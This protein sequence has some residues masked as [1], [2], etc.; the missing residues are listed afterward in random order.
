MYRDVNALIKKGILR[1]PYYVNFVLGMMYQGAIDATPE[2]LF[3]M[4]SF[5]PENAY[6]NV[7]ATSREQLP[8]T[9]M[10]ILMGGGCRVGLEDNIYYAKGVLAKSNAQLVARSVRIAREL[11]IEPLSAKDAREILHI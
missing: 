8:I 9:T 5:L 6:F 11:N 4:Y 10:G 7:T 3:S 2:N 1:P